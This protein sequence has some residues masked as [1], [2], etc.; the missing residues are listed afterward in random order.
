VALRDVSFKIV[1]GETFGIIGRNGSGKST[2][3]S[4]VAGVIRQDRG[5]VDVNGR[6]SSLLELGAG[7]HPDLSG[8]ENII[9]NGILMGNTRRH[10]QKKLKKIIDFSEL[11]DFIYQ[12]LRTYSSGMHMR[13]GFSVAIHIDPEILLIDE[14][15]A[16]G[17]LSFQKKCIQK[18]LEFR[19][20]GATLIIVSHEMNSISK[21]C[22]RV[23]WIDNGSVMSVGKPVETIE[24][25]MAFS[26]EKKELHHF[27]EVCES[28]ETAGDALP[29]A[30]AP[31]QNV[32]AVRPAV[33]WWDSPHVV[34]MS[35]N[36]ITGSPETSFYDYIKRKYGLQ[37]LDK[38]LS[39][40]NRLKGLESNFVLYNI[41]SSFD[42]IKNED[43]IESIRAGETRLE[44][45]Q[46]D[47]LLCT[48][49]LNRFVKPDVFLEKIVFS[50]K[51]NSI[52]FALEYLGPA[53]G[54][55]SDKEVQIA[56]TLSDMYTAVENQVDS[57]KNGSSLATSSQRR[58]SVSSRSP[59]SGDVIASVKHF[60]EIIDITYFGGPLYDLL[61]ARI[62]DNF[63]PNDY[64]DLKL[65]KTVIRIDQLFMKQGI[66]KGAYALIVARKR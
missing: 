14:A 63:D 12:P 62:L 1:K 47:V 26:A 29:D 13:L 66:L 3:L 16:V 37:K 4:L 24:R 36:I 50:L 31:S 35:E 46:Y 60:F 40:C 51:E 33:T 45:D 28:G 48:D 54:N 27:Q 43:D 42:V 25:Y 58:T 64:K 18:M 15:L 22:D 17:D 23:M 41:C 7:F 52:L 65:L 6:I 38:G 11:G 53:H 9:M 5:V 44:K 30:S 10:M 8:V 57:E 32:D 21:V 19:E 34:E 49:L 56:G 20:S 61:V 55:W 59:G 2:I 39:I